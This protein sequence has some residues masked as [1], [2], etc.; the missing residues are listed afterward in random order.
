MRRVTVVGLVAAML[1]ALGCGEGEP[2]VYRCNYESQA[3]CVDFA[4]VT[5]PLSA[6]DR[7][8]LM[9]E[10]SAAGGAWTSTSACPTAN[11]VGT[12]EQTRPPFVAGSS[13]VIADLRVY[14]PTTAATG[15][16][17]CNRVGGTWTAD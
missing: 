12:C 13:Q 11:R 7:A 15:E 10:C 9:N 2:L 14:P 17:D 16:A 8:V 3:E 6:F 5:G 4:A 1:S